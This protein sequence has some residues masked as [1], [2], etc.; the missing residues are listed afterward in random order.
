[1]NLLEV[2][3]ISVDYGGIHALRNVS[4]TIPEKGVVAI[5]GANGAG[6]STLLKT[7]AGLVAQNDGSI[8]LGHEDISRL[9]THERID[10]GVVLCPEGRRLFSELTVYENIRMGAYRMR[11][12]QEF[13]ERL[14]FLYGIFPRVAE[15]RNQVASSLSGGEQQMVAIAR[16]LINK[17]RVLMLDE[18]TLGLAPKLIIEVGNLVQTINKEGVTVLLVEQNAK[19]AL[20]ISDYGFVIETGSI[21]LQGDSADLLKS[22]E[23]SSIYLGGGKGEH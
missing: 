18:P 3:N 5:I 7:I 11:D 23:V 2:R 22:E 9:R 13:R 14:D 17:P 20:K 16:S 21:A 6:K 8:H 19:L 12:K 4:V 15:R 10:R 1:M